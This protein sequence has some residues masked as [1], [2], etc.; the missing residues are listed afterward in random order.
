MSK[1]LEQ[2]FNEKWVENPETGCWDWTAYRLPKGYGQIK[3]R[4]KMRAAHR[5]SYELHVGP[6]PEG[7]GY[8]GT[9]VCH[10]CDRPCCVNPEHLFPGTNEDNS[11]DKEEKGRGNHA[12]GES[13]GSA[14]LTA[15]E[16]ALIK[17][18]LER[19]PRGGVSFL[20]RWFG[21]AHTTIG[22]IKRGRCWS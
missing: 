7:E 8:H 21:V 14:K 13:H 10:R 4:G 6:I 5:V 11:R 17:E 1:T 3:S 19:L 15:A 9:C 22:R 16:V 2:R 18:A 20:A 12:K